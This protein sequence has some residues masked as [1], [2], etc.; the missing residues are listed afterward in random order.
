MRARNGR[1]ARDAGTRFETA[2]VRYLAAVLDDDRIER[3]AR[4][5]SKDRGDI[6]GVRI[7]GQRI[8]VEC[9]SVARTALAQ[10]IAQAHDEA[11]HDDALAG[12]IVHKRHGVSDPGQQWVTMT[13]EDLAK[14]ITGQQVGACDKDAA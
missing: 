2:I 6:S 5:G 14:L 13:V 9:K 7:H 1:S 10:W 11:N 8:V 4:T 3:R 12:I